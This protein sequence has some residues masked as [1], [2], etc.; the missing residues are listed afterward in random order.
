[1]NF[2]SLRP[3]EC[4][5][6]PFPDYEIM[7]LKAA[8]KCKYSRRYMVAIA[9][10]VELEELPVPGSFLALLYYHLHVFNVHVWWKYYP[11]QHQ[12]QL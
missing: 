6:V 12:V 8:E 11:L 3:E 1:M 9:E 2:H 5:H 7:Q 4:H 10:K